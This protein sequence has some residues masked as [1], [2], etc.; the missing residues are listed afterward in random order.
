MKE[1]SYVIT[2]N[3]ITPKILFASASFS[4]FFSLISDWNFAAFFTL[5]I[6]CRLRST[7]K[8]GFYLPPAFPAPKTH[9]L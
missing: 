7:T 5:H 2:A 1:F 9:I 4:P 3:P 8:A 6:I